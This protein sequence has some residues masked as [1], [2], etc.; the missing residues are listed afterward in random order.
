MNPESRLLELGL[1]PSKITNLSRNKDALAFF[2]KMVE[3]DGVAQKLTAHQI[4]LLTSLAIN[5]G[6]L[7]ADTRFYILRHVLDDQITT[8]VQLTEAIG[9]FMRGGDSSDEQSFRAA[10]G[11][12]V[13][14]T[15]EDVRSA[16]TSVLE[17]QPPADWD[18][19]RAALANLKVAPQLRW[20]DPTSLK[21]ETEA[22]FTRELG[23]RSDHSKHKPKI[24][25]V[26][27]QPDTNAQPTTNIFE[28]GFLASLHKPGENPQIDDKFRIEHLKAT[29]GKV[30]TRFPPEP[31]GFL[32]I[33]HA[34]AIAVN[35]GYAKYHGGL[36]YLRYDD[37]NPSKEEH[38]Y[39][40][41]ILTA[42]RWLGI[43]PDKVTYS[44]DYFDILFD[45][46]VEL[47]K[48]DKAYVCECTY[49]ERGQ[50]RGS[51]GMVKSR[52]ECVHRRR[53]I[54]E[55]F[56]MFE[57]MKDGHPELAN[58]TLRMKQDLTDG[59]PQMWD[60]VAYR[61]FSRPH[62]RTGTQWN[63]Y[64]TY[65]FAH[66]LV[67][68]LENISH[69]LCT[70]E[71]VAS[72]QSYEW[73][74]HALE[75]YTPRQYEYGRL[76]LT[77]TVMS[78]HGLIQER[79]VTGWDDI[80]LPT[81]IAL[82]RRGVPPEAIMHFVRGLGVTTAMAVTDAAK[83]DE[84]IRRFLEPSPRLFLI[85]RPIKIIYIDADDF[86]VSGSKDYLRLVPGGL[87]H[88]PHPITCTSFQFDD[89]GNVHTIIAHYHDS[90]QEPVAKPKAFIHWVA[91]CSTRQSP[92][93]VNQVRLV[94]PLFKSSSPTGDEEIDGSS[95]DALSGALI[96]IGFWDV[97]KEALRTARE[98]ARL[99]ILATPTSPGVPPI[100]E[101][102]LVGPE[103][104][105]F[106]ATR[107]GYFSLDSDSIVPALESLE[108]TASSGLTSHIVLNRIVSLKEG[109]V[110][111]A[112]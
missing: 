112:K 54:D 92:I 105:R 44:S 20:A 43:E 29:G 101:T 4:N 102:Q 35:F 65:D 111:L 48:N 106:Q 91:E 10:C 49:E 66:C 11:A 69:S 70:S 84:C 72:R 58:A 77:H 17:I 47:I 52:Q 37:T 28:Q 94:G 98:A 60:L 6:I 61:T 30:V 82:R 75:I 23:P 110:R 3:N 88:V 53:P 59:N 76:Y 19:L 41:S 63:V 81:L 86:R 62:P 78:N 9:Y 22:V 26:V 97:A 14:L 89:E 73:L 18:G 32:H 71:F 57:Q 85:L 99:R 39:F 1:A 55:S 51:K 87:M 33:G 27:K 2:M 34:K 68:S 21:E 103:C 38:I 15:R 83:F 36:C 93:R 7:P 108:D 50:G 42:V 5:G 104:V 16:V 100:V 24:K 74:C 46:A 64:P 13:H 96:E 56:L 107:V 67:D 45:K 31:N 12:G 90:D 40:E 80:R 79:R 8:Q 109:D 95:L 25:T